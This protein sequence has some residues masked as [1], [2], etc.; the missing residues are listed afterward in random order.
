M[1]LFY[2]QKLDVW[3]N[4]RKL[5]R[6]VYIVTQ[7]FPDDEKYNLVS[8]LRRASISV[9]S[10]IAEGIA[11]NSIRDQIRFT[12]I[13]FGSLMELLNLLI[14]CMDL[15]YLKENQF[16]SLQNQVEII[17]RQLNALNKSRQQSFN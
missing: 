9:P 5:V 17:A 15:E 7:S 1:Y 6:D 14:L 13:S 16:D 4:S 12:R 11:R 8:Q 3:K 10:N 2:F